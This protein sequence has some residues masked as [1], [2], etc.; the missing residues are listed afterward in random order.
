MMC[1]MELVAYFK[2]LF[3][4]FC[5]KKPGH[6]TGLRLAFLEGAA[7]CSSAMKFMER[8]VWFL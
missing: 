8:M 5:V 7:G 4:E 2:F 1:Q 3:L 6:C